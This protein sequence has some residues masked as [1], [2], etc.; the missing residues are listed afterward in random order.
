MRDIPYIAACDDYLSERTRNRNSV[1]F[2]T[3]PRSDTGARITSP[4]AFFFW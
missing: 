3:V 2:L 4:G 1:T